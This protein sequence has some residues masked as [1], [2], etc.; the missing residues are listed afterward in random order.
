MSLFQG[1]TNT[2]L[3]AWHTLALEEMKK[4]SFDMKTLQAPPQSSIKPNE[5]LAEEADV[6][7]SEEELQKLTPAKRRMIQRTRKVKMEE[8][9]RAQRRKIQKIQRG[10]IKSFLQMLHSQEKIANQLLE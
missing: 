4:R 5:D 8:K 2:E 9:E 6:E 3:S 10:K 7:M 1:F